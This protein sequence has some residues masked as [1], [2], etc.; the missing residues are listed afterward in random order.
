MVIRLFFVASQS[1]IAMLVKDGSQQD[2]IFPVYHK[3]SS[4]GWKQGIVVP[5]RAGEFFVFFTG[6]FC[7]A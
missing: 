7:P 5:C 3:H 4:R 1:G 6:L 2:I